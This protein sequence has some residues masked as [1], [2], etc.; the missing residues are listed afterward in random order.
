MSTTN[1]NPKAVK[2]VLQE[3]VVIAVIGAMLAVAAIVGGLA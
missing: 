3:L 2:A 1:Y